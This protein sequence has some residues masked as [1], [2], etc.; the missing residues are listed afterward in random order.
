MCVC[1]WVAHIVE[2]LVENSLRWFEY[3]KRKLI[4]VVVRRVDQMK[5][6]QVKGGRGKP[7]KT[8][9]ETIKKDLEVN[10]LN[11]NLIYDTT[12]WRNL[13]HIADPT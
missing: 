2:K 3:V 11:P 4:D 13:I 8:I 5:E 7:R 12:L 9:R 1:V 10:E 6:S